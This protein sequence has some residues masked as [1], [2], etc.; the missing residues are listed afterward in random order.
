MLCAWP[1]DS[2]SQ[3][4]YKVGVSQDWAWIIGGRVSLVS[5][6]SSWLGNGQLALM[7]SREVASTQ[8]LLNKV[9]L[10]DFN[11]DLSVEPL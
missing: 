9:S 1:E 10:V 5:I 11:L 4:K 8:G 3:L 2:R 7:W 6:V